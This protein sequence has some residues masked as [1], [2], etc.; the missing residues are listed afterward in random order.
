[1]TSASTRDP[2]NIDRRLVARMPESAR[3]MLASRASEP[4]D[5]TEFIFE[6][7]WGGI[8]AMAFVRDGYARLAGSN[9]RD[10]TPLFPELASLPELLHAREAILDGEIV[11]LDAQGTPAFELLRPRLHALAAGVP[12]DAVKPKRIAG[13]LTFQAS[14]IL[15][16]DGRS[17]V[18]MPLWQRKN[19][20]HDAITPAPEFA[21]VD[22]VDDEGVAFFEAVLERRLDGIVAKRKNSAY[23][24]GERSRDWL[25]VRALQAADFVVGGYTFGGARRKGEPFGQLLVGAYAGARAG[26]KLEFV[27]AVSGGLS[28]AEAKRLVALLEPLVVDAPP[29]AESPDIPR[30]IYWTQPSMACRVRFSEWSREGLLRFPIFSA[31]R[32]DVDAAS[33][34]VG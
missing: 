34:V 22:F 30:L 7:L 29:F 8:R 25:E 26:E 23:R 14:D 9:G 24:A 13:Q 4:F 31:L 27:G 19:R 28:D 2:S 11:A 12:A 17:L 32:P 10:L 18:E 15:W 5:S 33:C 16:L 3:P 20:L 1:M 21:A 6:L